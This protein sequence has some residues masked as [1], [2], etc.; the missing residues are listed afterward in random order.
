MFSSVHA[1][2]A[3]TIGPPIPARD[4]KVDGCEA[5][6]RA[7]TV[8]ERMPAT[9]L[10]SA[11]SRSRLCLA[12]WCTPGFSRLAGIRANRLTFMSRTR[13]A[14]RVQT[15]SPNDSDAEALREG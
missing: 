12:V 2:S 10:A 7:A 4:I 13:L 14:T 8:R 3:R 1:A 15:L 6:S 5:S 9:E 11:P